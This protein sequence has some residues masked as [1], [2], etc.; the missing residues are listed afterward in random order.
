V[1]EVDLLGFGFQVFMGDEVEVRRAGPGDAGALGRIA[2]AAKGHW[3]YPGRWMEL[4]R[5]GLEVSPAFVRDNEVYVAVSGG[6]PVGFYALV[7][8]GR[9]LDLEHL[10]VLP[11][12][13]G[14]GLGRRLFEHAMRRAKELGAGTVT[15]EA[16]PN[17]EG[18]YRKM[19]ARRAGENVYEIE[20]Q[21]R[22]LPVMIVG[23]TEE[24]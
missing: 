6:E 7:G 4:W 11:A 20:G 3:G 18:F 2:F 8:W 12:W 17:A 14:T 19:G 5:P 9:G 24:G 21:E 1:D 22:V 10:W 15:I 16:D 23:L 13:I